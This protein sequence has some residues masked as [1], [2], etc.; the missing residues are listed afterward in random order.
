MQLNENQQKTLIVGVI[1]AVLALVAVIVLNVTYFS[2]QRTELQ[3]N[4]STAETEIT[5]LESERALM[6]SFLGNE[7]EHRDLMQRVE[8]A[9]RR[10]PSDPQAFQFL[11]ILRDTLSNTNV[12]FSFLSQENSIRRSMYEEI[13]YR[14]RGAARYHEFGQ[15]INIIE[16]H[17]ERFM[18]VSTFS[19]SND[20]RRPSIH[21]I[22]VGISTF[23]FRS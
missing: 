22:E 19:L 21:P 8:D 12:N 3:Q 17:P 18:R 20:T 4:I 23:M 6:R 15:F 5:N 9:R 14:V 1:F 7:A 16:C 10:L 13:P 2:T 11:E